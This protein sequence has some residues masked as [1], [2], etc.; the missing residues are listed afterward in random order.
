MHLCTKIFL[1]T[2]VWTESVEAIKAANTYK[3]ERVITSPQRAS[4]GVTERTEPVLNFCAN[5]YLGLADDPQV[6]H[7]ATLPLLRTHAPA[8]AHQRRC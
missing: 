6:C 7:F 2:Q 5:N 8:L 3:R 1:C 4:I